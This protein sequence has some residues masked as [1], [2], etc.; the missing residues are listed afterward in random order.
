ME[1]K[2]LSTN[3]VGTELLTEGILPPKLSEKEIIPLFLDVYDPGCRYL[4]SAEVNAPKARGIFKAETTFV[5]KEKW[6]I[7]HFSAFE[8]VICFNQLCFVL[9]SKAI[10]DGYFKEIRPLTERQFLKTQT[11]RCFILSINSAVYK[12]AFLASDPFVGEIAIKEYIYKPE[13]RLLIA[14]VDFSFA[15]G[16][17]FGNITIAVKFTPD[18]VYPVAEEPRQ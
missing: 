18:E 17:A 7:G 1:K 6:N 10:R 16:R 11:D 9:F 2:T 13:K 8:N 12:R 14:P 5:T 4:R 15:E 3:Y